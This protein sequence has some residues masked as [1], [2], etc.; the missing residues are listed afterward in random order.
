MKKV[1]TAITVLLG[2]LATSGVLAAVPETLTYS[3]YLTEDGVAAE[4]TAAVGFELFTAEEGG[5]SVWSEAHASVQVEAGMFTVA[6]GSTESLMPV[7]DGNVYY[8]QV[9]IDGETMLPRTP[10]HSVP[11]AVKAGD[12]DTL[13]GQTAAEI[14][15]GVTVSAQADG[16]AYDNS[17]GD[18]ES[19]DMQ[20]VVAEL[21]ARIE[22]LEVQS[23]SQQ[24]LIETN[25]SAVA[26]NTA[27][28]ATNTTS[29]STNAANISTNA[30]FIGVNTTAIGTNASAISTNAS[31]IAANAAVISGNTAAAV[32]NAAAIST[33]ATDIAGNAAD[34]ITNALAIDDLE[35]LTSH[36]SRV[37]NE[38]YFTGA[39]INIVSGSGSTD[40]DINGL[41]NLIIGYNED[42]DE[43]SEK[44]GSHNL[45]I[46]SQN[47][48]SSYGGLVTGY[49]NTVSGEYS[50][51]S[52][53]TSNTAS[54]RQ[55]SKW[56][57]Q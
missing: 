21:L 2:L 31:A 6:L 39:N 5:T 49:Q 55:L 38:L 23:A 42:L 26:A 24:S 45:V 7:L 8:L 25:S 14:Q 3:G 28:V 51:V 27:L 10:F 34:I 56:W 40:G 52:G 13:G 12:A 9:T 54:G 37:D 35:Y 22:A 16:V 4:A 53:G 30:T 33:N 36:I 29:I 20:G 41:G 57:F 19:T 47:N 32:A 15:S 50:S 17:A 48:Y 18:L 46:G 11:Y 43:G 44:S 1:L